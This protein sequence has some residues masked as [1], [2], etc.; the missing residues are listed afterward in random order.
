MALSCARNSD[1]TRAGYRHGLVGQSSGIEAV[2]RLIDKV[3]PHREVPV[4]VLGETGTG[5]EL[6]ARAI[7]YVRPRGEF[8]PIDCGSLVGTL[9]ESELFGHTKG[10]FSGAID[11]KKGQVEIADGGT[12]FFDEIGELPLEMQVR[13]LRLLQEREFRPVGAPKWRKVDARIIAATNRDL[14]AEIAGKRFREDLFYRLKGCTIR[15]PPLR[16]RKEDIPLLIE[17]FQRSGRC[18]G[19]HPSPEV[20]EIFQS[21]DWP[22]NVRELQQ[23]IESMAVMYSQGEQVAHLPSAIRQQHA[24]RSLHTLSVAVNDEPQQTVWVA[25]KSPVISA[26]VISMQDSERQAI[27]TALDATGGDRA[28]T[29]KLLGIGRTTLYRKMK[30]YGIE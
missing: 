14:P 2:R 3:A 4:L 5:K 11:N 21:Y 9:M 6:V 28:K 17:H 26:P 15:V 22:G 8:V 18:G 20:L 10:A 16:E 27:A 25:P 30:Q 23:C 13:L 12:A 19:F 7:H 29:S 24:A 1:T